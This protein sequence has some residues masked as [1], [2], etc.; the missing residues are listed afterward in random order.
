MTRLFNRNKKTTIAELEEYYSN[1]EQKRNRPVMAWFMAFLSLL[2]TFVVLFVLFISIRWVYRELT[3]NNDSATTTT[4]D[5]A[6][7]AIDIDL[8][9]YDGDIVGQGNS[10]NDGGS[11]ATN[12]TSNGTSTDSDTSSNSGTVSEE[13]AS[14][15]ESNADRVASSTDSE[16]GQT[17]GSTTGSNANTGGEIPNTGA[18]ETLLAI[19]FVAAIAGY[20]IS[21]KKQLSQK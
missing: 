3:D 5:T 6:N 20:F 11:T 16:N 21:R 4:N 9:S 19:P 7:E 10:T 18:G 2:I 17:A 15:S 8:P 1:Q 14:T 13:A 12:G